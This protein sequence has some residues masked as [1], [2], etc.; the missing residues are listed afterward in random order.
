MLLFPIFVITHATK[1]KLYFFKTILSLAPHRLC[2]KQLSTVLRE[3]EGYTHPAMPEPSANYGRAVLVLAA[4]G[5]EKEK[6]G[7]A[8]LA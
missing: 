3:E 7:A 2:T 5:G 1:S 8:L 6:P 4:L